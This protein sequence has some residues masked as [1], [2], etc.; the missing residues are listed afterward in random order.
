[1][2][3]RAFAMLAAFSLLLFVATGVLWVR[4]YWACDMVQWTG[5]HWQTVGAAGTR[6]GL[7]L[8][9]AWPLQKVRVEFEGE[10]SR[11]G[12]PVAEGAA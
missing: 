7:I 4:S 6:G 1:M 2:A 12:T 9:T 8:V 3:R 5:S 10:F 11:K